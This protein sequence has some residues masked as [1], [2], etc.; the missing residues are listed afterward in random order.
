MVT[1][2]Y[3]G[4]IEYSSSVGKDLQRY[5]AQLPDLFKVNQKLK[6]TSEDIVLT[7]PGH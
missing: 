5:L 1:S 7:P 2:K 6:H 4:R 3:R